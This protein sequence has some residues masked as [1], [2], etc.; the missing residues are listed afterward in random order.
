MKKRSKTGRQRDKKAVLQS[1]TQSKKLSGSKKKTSTPT[2]KA[3]KQKPKGEFPSRKDQIKP[4]EVRNPKGRP[5]LPSLTSLLS[6][7]LN[8]PSDKKP[9]ILKADEIVMA[10]L[11]KARKGDTKALDM[12]FNRHDG[13]VVQKIRA[14]MLQGKLGELTDAEL[15]QIIESENKE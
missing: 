12:V 10:L 7:M 15:D 5:P 4:G 14:S 6:N 13:K 2:S 11:R 1:R 9:D 8:E 3:K